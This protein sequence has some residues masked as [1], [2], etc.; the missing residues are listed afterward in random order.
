MTRRLYTLAYPVLDPR[1]KNMIDAFRTRYDL[2]YRDVVRPHFTMVFGIAD[3][4][5]SDYIQ[6]VSAVAKTARR[7]SFDVC[8]AMLG[9]DDESDIAHVFLVPDGGYGALSR[10]HDRL[11]SGHFASKLRLDI[12]YVPH[13]TIGTLTDRRAAKA[14]CDELNDRGLTISGAVESLTV[15][16]LENGV[17]RDLG[18]FPMLG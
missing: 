10:L 15:G 8:Y 6:H 17:V 12:P 18:S 14:L 2:P 4:A 13:I 1:D 5:D 9:A 3:M 16:A 7:V 11:Y